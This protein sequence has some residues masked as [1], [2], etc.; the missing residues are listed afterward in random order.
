MLEKLLPLILT[1]LD[2]ISFSFS[3]SFL[4]RSFFCEG[5]SF[6]LY[7]LKSFEFPH[8]IFTFLPI[9]SPS[10]GGIIAQSPFL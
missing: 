5:S 4:A 9:A 1:N 2:I 7:S 8:S 6:R 10:Y 3:G